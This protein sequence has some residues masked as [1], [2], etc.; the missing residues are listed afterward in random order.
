V[1]KASFPFVEP[2]F[3]ETSTGATNKGISLVFSS[4][5]G[6]TDALAEKSQQKEKK[7]EKKKEKA[8]T[9]PL[10]SAAPARPDHCCASCF[11]RANS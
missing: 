4:S 1:V 3:L 11:L 7:R 5:S 6:M 2:F 10:R 9:S 8:P